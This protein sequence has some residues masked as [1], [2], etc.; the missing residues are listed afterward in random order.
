MPDGADERPVF[1]LGLCLAGAVSAGSYTA[2][3]LDRLCE[4]L[5]AWE[6]IHAGETVAGWTRE[7]LPP[8]R[9]VIEVIGGASAG[10]MVGTLLASHW[11][12][13]A[14]EQARAE[15]NGPDPS[16]G[17]PT[18]HDIWVGLG[19]DD[20]P[21][22]GLDQ[23]QVDAMT[24]TDDLVD[25]GPI[26][27]LLNSAFIDHLAR[28][29]VR[30]TTAP[31]PDILRHLPPYVSRRLQL[32]MTHTT[33]QG[34]PLPVD[35]HAP[36]PPGQPGDERV[37]S[38]TY[39]HHL[40]T[41]FTL[42]DEHG[43][44]PGGFLP[45]R[46][47]GEQGAE[48]LRSCAKATGAF[49]MGLANRPLPA[50]VVDRPY[51]EAAVNRNLYRDYA[52]LDKETIE[53]RRE[54]RGLKPKVTIPA[55]APPVQTVD[56]GAINN[57]PFSE[58]R[59]MLHGTLDTPLADGPGIL[60]DR[61]GTPT[62]GLV[63]ID[64]FPDRTRSGDA[65]GQADVLRVTPRLAKTLWNGAKTKR[66]EMTESDRC[67]MIRGQ[68]FP[69]RWRKAR[70]EEF[71]PRGDA[72]NGKAGKALLPD[73][74]PLATSAAE[75][76]GG[77]LSRAFREHDYRLGH[78]NARNFFGYWFRLEASGPGAAEPS[79]G[80]A[81]PFR[82]RTMRWP[83]ERPWGSQA[84][85]E[86]FAIRQDGRVYYPILPDFTRPKGGSADP[87]PASLPR[88][89][90][91]DEVLALTEAELPRWARYPPAVRQ[92]PFLTDA[93]L[94]RLDQAL[95]RRFRALVR[96]LPAAIRA[97]SLP[98]N[99]GPSC[100]EKEALERAATAAWYRRLKRKA[101][102]PAW[103][104]SIV[105]TAL[106]GIFWLLHGMLV[107]AMV[108]GTMVWLYRDLAEKD[109]YRPTAEPSS[110][111]HQQAVPTGQVGA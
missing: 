65:L 46:T 109:L 108:R 33:L 79:E 56:G 8:Y 23:P 31:W 17:V 91:H 97:G 72:P 70:K 59:D 45:L 20:T 25:G 95:E 15:A 99:D 100:A 29:G 55:M 54:A 74:H 12:A 105:K 61:N 90:S 103:W 36:G 27:S 80:A 34:I 41:H 96:Q 81:V 102:R 22:D 68:I 1:R 42:P 48:R 24:A 3:A 52:L 89:R 93:D 60:R 107:R 35:F 57:E 76:F 87:A 32:L 14:D 9:V 7:D 63:F 78:E 5:D 110:V 28:R 37:E 49:P 66:R 106:G 92:R 64:P 4:L 19:R 62:M 94:R 86:A 88:F 73:E 85:R 101:E 21:R 18:L 82:A 58:V 71:V 47:D 44:V 50:D 84:A 104:R 13:K 51:L 43:R 2:G 6:R 11:L 75:A 111:Q 38:T 77:L 40:Q 16:R 26:P 83:A 39:E 98:D 53:R 69:R 67:L 10:G 30:E